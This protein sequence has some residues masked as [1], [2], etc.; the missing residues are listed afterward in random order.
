MYSL[1][2]QN[3]GDK[4][5]LYFDSSYR[6]QALSRLGLIISWWSGLICLGFSIRFITNQNGAYLDL[7]IYTKEILPLALNVLVTCINE[8][9]G[10]IHTNSLRWALQREGRLAFNSNLRL[11]TSAR[12]SKT[13]AWYANICMLLCIVMSYASTPLIFMGDIPL[14]QSARTANSLLP[15]NS[16]NF[17]CGYALFTLAIGIFG[18]CIIA[19]AALYSAVDS[20]TWSQNPIDTAAACAAA[21]AINPVPN[22]CLRSVHDEEQDASPVVPVS[23]QRPAYTTH[24]EARLVLFCI[25][26]TVALALLWGGVLIAV[27]KNFKT[28]N[29]IYYGH[30]WA[31]FPARPKSKDLSDAVF[32]GID[33]SG[34]MTLAIPWNVIAQYEGLDTASPYVSFPSFCWAFA[35][36]CL[37][38]TVM[39]VS[40]HCAELLV[41]VVRDE[42]TWRRAG[43]R[44][45]VSES[46][47]GLS[48]KPMN[49]LHALL[50]SVPAMTLFLYKPILHW[51]FS[52]AVSA[53]FS[54]G[55]VMRPP[56]II[57][58]SIGAA[59]LASFVSALAFWQ[60]KGAQPATFGHLQTLV[61]LIDEW[62]EEGE[63]MFWGRKAG[64]KSIKNWR[65]EETLKGGSRTT[66]RE[67]LETDSLEAT[68]VAHAGTSAMKLDDVRFNELYVGDGR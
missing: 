44:S 30:S 7:N 42:K 65:E 27:I 1:T 53:Y 58:L 19:S 59:L 55:L 43:R 41:N 36:I 4:V 47:L 64:G 31:F 9:L 24:K 25:W 45:G 34:T 29:G 22:R 10:Y 3:S 67:V 26:V 63:H 32:K 8:A 35:L 15:D 49:A 6:S 50:V 62:P 60:P 66:S 40:L 13:N 48:R 38:Q 68:V 57:Y 46:N 28:V 61:N 39:T 2:P 51:I 17:V 37:L 54:V 20:P 5:R 52:L 11:F 56:Q 16:T 21:A 12:T 33:T 23:R 14:A 18:Q